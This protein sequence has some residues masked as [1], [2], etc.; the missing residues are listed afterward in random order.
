M[1]FHVTMT[2]TPDNC[3]SY[4]PPEK[5]PEVVAAMDQQDAI[6][7][8]LNVKVHSFVNTAPGHVSYALLE[9][10]SHSSILSWIMA[11]PIREDYNIV[12]VMHQ[13]D[14]MAFARDMMTKMSEK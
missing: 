9:A 12:P 7:K 3:P 13:W 11:I 4:W 5:W 1:L 8:D 2:H 10:D 14:L 6:A